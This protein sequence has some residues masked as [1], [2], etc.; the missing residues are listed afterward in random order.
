M[1]RIDLQPLRPNLCRDNPQ[2]FSLEG[3]TMCVRYP[4]HDYGTGIK[5]KGGQYG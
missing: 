4:V 3:D 5:E 2:G 1:T